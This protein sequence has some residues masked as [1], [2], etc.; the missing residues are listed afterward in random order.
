MTA[1]HDNAD[2]DFSAADPLAEEWRDLPDEVSDIIA[3][4]TLM[5]AV[6][7]DPFATSHLDDCLPQAGLGPSALARYERASS[8]FLKSCRTDNQDDEAQELLRRIAL[9]WLRKSKPIWL[10]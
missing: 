4:E 1:E 5:Q 7:E 10:D 2:F 3:F 8:A 9:Y 6:S